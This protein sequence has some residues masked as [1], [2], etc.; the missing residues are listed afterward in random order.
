MIAES[1]DFY[2]S[3]REAILSRRGASHHRSPVKL[4]VLKLLELLP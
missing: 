4:G 3:H 1:Y 2:V